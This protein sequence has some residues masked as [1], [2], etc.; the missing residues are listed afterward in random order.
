[1]REAVRA[2]DPAQA[3][4]YFFKPMEERV[5]ESLGPRRF[6]VTMLIAFASIALAM[7]AVGLYGVIS[8]AVSQRTQEIGIRM[9]LGARMAQVL[10]MVLLDAMKL[11]SI[12]VAIGL[13]AGLILAK[14]LAAEL[15]QISAF[16]PM[17]FAAM[18][19]MLT[20][21]TLAATY[22]PAH[23]AARIDPLVALRYE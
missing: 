20:I 2:V 14:S 1:M 6:A 9:A 10:G 23:R 21:V 5:W 13:C 7:A 12:G 15:I 17:T 4:I 16:D 11:V 22:L 8:Y 18:A 19:V 3:A